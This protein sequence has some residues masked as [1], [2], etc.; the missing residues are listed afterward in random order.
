M[1]VCC[2]ADVL[3]CSG[4]L[5]FWCTRLLR[6]GSSGGCDGD[7][8]LRN[9]GA[10][11]SRARPRFSDLLGR[12][13]EANGSRTFSGRKT[14]QRERGIFSA[15]CTYVHMYECMYASMYVCMYAEN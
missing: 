3:V 8:G 6:T 4:V 7:N 12:E 13:G 14:G 2:C 5:V 1:P 15:V 9:A 11:A 10:F